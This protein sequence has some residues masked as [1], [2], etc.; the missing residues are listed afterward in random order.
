[1]SQAV[2][3]VEGMPAP[4]PRPDAHDCRKAGT[5]LGAIHVAAVSYDEGLENPR[6]RAWRESFAERLRTR[7]SA[8]E[9]RKPIS[10]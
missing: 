3:A 9:A 5:I 8:D 2:T 6:G 4:K 1:M 10:R 7:I